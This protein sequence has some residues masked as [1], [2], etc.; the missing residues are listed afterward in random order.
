MNIFI[1][2]LNMLKMTVAKRSEH[3]WTPVTSLDFRTN[4]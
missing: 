4:Y 3:W 1:Y 2:T